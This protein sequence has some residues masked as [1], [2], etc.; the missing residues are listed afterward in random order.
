MS[1]S[2]KNVNLLYVVRETPAG[3]KV[4]I[5]VYDDAEGV[6][7]RARSEEANGNTALVLQA[8]M[9]RPSESQTNLRRLIYL[10]DQ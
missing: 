5:A 6:K 2:V 3:P 8:K 4:A 7:K 10:T 1:S 9:Y